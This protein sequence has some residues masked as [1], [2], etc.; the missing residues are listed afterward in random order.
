MFYSCCTLITQQTKA[1][2]C[3]ANTCGYLQACKCTWSWKHRGPSRRT[4][5]GRPHHFCVQPQRHMPTP[6]LPPSQT[7]PPQSPSFAQSLHNCFL[8]ILRLNVVCSFP[9]TQ[10][11]TQ[12]FC[13]SKSGTHKPGILSSIFP[14]EFSC[15]VPPQ[16]PRP[17]GHT[18]S[19]L[20]WKPSSQPSGQFQS[21]YLSRVTTAVQM[22]TIESGG[23]W[24]E[25]LGRLWTHSKH[26]PGC[27]Y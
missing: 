25:V 4:A 2:R 1:T 18:E 14:L 21:G 12:Q 3:S 10:E 24:G 15:W 23:I 7:R 11:T 19:A 13:F 27:Y 17:G 26:V 22:G 9:L 16:G 8:D 5:P 20:C 6:R